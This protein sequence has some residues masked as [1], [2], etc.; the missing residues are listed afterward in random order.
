MCTAIAYRRIYCHSIQHWPLGNIRHLTAGSGDF[1]LN[2]A[3]E[4]A[5]GEA[6]P[7]LL[8]CDRQGCLVWVSG[9]PQSEVGV[10]ESLA[11]EFAGWIGSG[12]SYRVWP[13]LALPDTLLIGAQAERQGETDTIR[14]EDRIL[15]HYSRL[16]RAQRELSDRARLRG[17]GRG[18]R[19]ARQIELER[20]RLGRELHTGV[21]Q[22]LAAIGLQLEAIATQMPHPPES[23]QRALDAIGR[24][25]G[26][27]LEQVSGISR[28]LH[29]PEW[30]RLTLETALSQL[31]EVTGIPQRFQG[32]LSI[33][34]LPEEPAQQI[35][36]LFYRAAQEGLANIARHSAATRVEMTLAARSGTVSLTIG[37]DGRGFDAQRMAAAPASIERGIGLRSIREEAAGLG[38]RLEIRSGPGG[39]FLRVQGPF[40]PRN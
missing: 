34:T 1:W 28:R 18:C 15:R 39:T 36:A 37:D 16:Q 8:G 33:Q 12:A 25:A 2:E 7:S 27:A 4:S 6:H 32:R 11:A 21:G 19:A 24:L 9:Y 29:P 30:Q 22:M 3:S 13:V 5:T 38:A 23:I 17:S 31:W 20:Q 35:K 14:I 26:G 10:R 40:S